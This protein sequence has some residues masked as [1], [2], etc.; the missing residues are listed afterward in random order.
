MSTILNSNH[1]FSLES[2]HSTSRFWHNPLW[3]WSLCF[4]NILHRIYIFIWW[5]MLTITLP[6][7]INKM[8]SPIWS[9]ISFTNSVLMTSATWS[10]ILVLKLLN[11]NKVWLG[12]SWGDKNDRY[13]LTLLWIQMLTPTIVGEPLSDLGRYRLESSIIPEW[14]DRISLLLWVCYKS[15]YDFRCDFIGMQLFEFCDR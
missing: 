12:H 11:P 15:V 6:H 14:L 13:L 2:S 7:A 5:F 3:I 9:N 1:E 10:I 8:V 4:I